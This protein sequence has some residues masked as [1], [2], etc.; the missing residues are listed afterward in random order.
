MSDT[1]NTAWPWKGV[2]LRRRDFITLIGVAA[3]VWPR[4]AREQEAPTRPLIGLL[5]PLEPAR[6]TRNVEEFRKGLH[7]L[8]LFE[9]RNIALELRFANGVPSRLPQLAA[10]LVALKPNVIHVGSA[11][12]IQAAH[13]A[14]ETI[15]LVMITGGN[16]V[17]LGL[18]KSIAR[19]GTNITGT[20]L[21]ADEGLFG[22]RL[23]LLKE[24][25]PGLARVGVMFNPDE[26]HTAVG[27][28]LLP[29]AARA[30]DLEL[31]FIEV[32]A[33]SELDAA[34]AK[35][36]RE[37]M[38]ALYIIG[39]PLFDSNRRAVAAIAERVRLPTIHSW[40]EYAEDGCLMSYGPSL[41]HIYRSSARIVAK[42]LK[43]RSPAELPVEIPRRYELVVNLKTAKT[44]GLTISESFLLLADEVIE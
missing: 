3:V 22:K 18:V 36:A 24:V 20:W 13:N 10:E 15:P 40:R 21:A 31:H 7:D 6:A 29:P 17:A 37:G 23:A 8:G 4:S 43:G 28:R 41:P 32:R 33:T 35:A 34:F 38:K 26:I 25:V 1:E 19:P 9:G 39:G 14:T 30:L 12:G 16:P 44:L 5:S 27:L 2:G 42:I 11:A